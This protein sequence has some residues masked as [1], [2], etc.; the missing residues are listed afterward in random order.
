[1]IDKLNSFKKK[2]S[3]I[4]ILV[5]III[6]LCVAYVITNLNSIHVIRNETQRS[7]IGLEK[8]GY[9]VLEL[10][11]TQLLKININIPFD[12]KKNSQIAFDLIQDDVK[13]T[14]VYRIKSRD[15]SWT[16]L[17][18]KFNYNKF[19]N[20]K[21]ILKVNF[22]KTNLG[23]LFL[24]SKVKEID[25]YVGEY[26]IDNHNTGYVLNVINQTCTFKN[27]F[28]YFILSFI[29]LSGLIYIIK[30][31]PKFP[32]TCLYLCLVISQALRLNLENL[33]ITDEWVLSTWLINYKDGF[34]DRGLI[35]SLIYGVKEFF[36][37]DFFIS[38]QMLS[39]III[40]IYF[41]VFVLIGCFINLCERRKIISKFALIIWVLSPSFITYF[42]N[43]KTI[44]RIDLLLIA[45]YLISLYFINKKKY[46]AG[47]VV[48]CLALMTYEAYACLSLPFVILY[49]AYMVVIK[50]NSNNSKSRVLFF[51]YCVSL[52]FLSFYLHLYG[53]LDPNII[54]FEY[55]CKEI[56]DITNFKISCDILSFYPFQ[57]PN[58]YQPEI[59]IFHYHFLIFLNL[60]LLTVFFIYFFIPFVFLFKKSSFYKKN[61]YIG[62]FLTIFGLAITIISHTAFDYHRYITLYYNSFIIFILFLCISDNAIKLSLTFLYNS[63]FRKSWKYILVFYGLSFLLDFSQ[64]GVQPITQYGNNVIFII[65]NLFS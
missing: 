8:K 13:D 31:I 34:I 26:Y 3:K 17:D 12:R 45:F 21:A 15:Y 10:H 20:N 64:S 52:I 51:V 60:I 29:L 47:F 61:F 59:E 58:S 38:K 22:E 24:R 57:R 65:N 36:N 39:N 62:I 37:S 48:S 27:F 11:N 42:L 23:F 14:Y 18:L 32:I 43:D 6:T 40:I 49:M 30:K 25:P 56:Y 63:I 55:F 28:K 5:L 44:G 2:Y 7:T 35:G 16:W 33:P 53:R 41:F 1:M 50:S 4:K 19:R 46:F 9:Q 54:S